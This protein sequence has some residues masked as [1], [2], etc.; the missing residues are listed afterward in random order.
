M[1]NNG[2]MPWDSNNVPMQGIGQQGGVQPLNTNAA[3]LTANTVYLFKWGPSAN[4]QVNHLM[5]QNNST[6]NVNFELDNEVTVGSAVIQP[7]QTVFLDI[8]TIVLHLLSSGTPN[9]NGST[10]GN[11]V[12][13]GWL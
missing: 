6:V 1:A 10:A 4:Q 3:A 7:G 5:I 12:V 8:Q 11:I 9:V 2:I 13:R